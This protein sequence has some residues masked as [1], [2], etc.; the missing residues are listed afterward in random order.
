MEEL[1]TVSKKTISRI[2]LG[3]ITK[4][5]RATREK[6]AKALGVEVPDLAKQAGERETIERDLKNAGYRKLNGYI[7]PET[8]LGYAM[9]Q[10]RFGVSPRGV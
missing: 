2:E 5:N 8:A 6:L 3:Q 4:P 7:D 1:S 9:I 10:H